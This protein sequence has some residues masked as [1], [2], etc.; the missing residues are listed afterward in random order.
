MYLKFLVL[1][2]FLQIFSITLTEYLSYGCLPNLTGE[3]FIFLTVL[4]TV[5]NMTLLLFMMIIHFFKF[6]KIINTL[7][8]SILVSA[9]IIL[10]SFLYAKNLI[11]LE[12]YPALFLL[13]L[14]F[15]LSLCMSF[16]FISYIYQVYLNKKA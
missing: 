6:S 2:F 3:G 15:T 4:L 7:M 11:N 14:I 8:L 12:Q 16:K 5:T 10:F 1:H 9:E 13:K